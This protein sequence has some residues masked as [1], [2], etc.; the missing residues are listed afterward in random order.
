MVSDDVKR[1]LTDFINDHPSVRNKKLFDGGDLYQTVT[2]E[3][4]KELKN[5][6]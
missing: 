4:I 3:L 5:A 1:F 6:N 2:H